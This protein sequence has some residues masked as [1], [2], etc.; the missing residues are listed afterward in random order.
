MAIR[1]RPDRKGIAALLIS[2]GMQEL[3]RRAAEEGKRYAVSISPDA[4]PYGAGYIASFRVEFGL[5]RKE[6]G[7]KRATSELWNDSD[8]AAAVEWRHGQRVL[9]RTADHI[10]SWDPQ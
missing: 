8:H 1:Y 7:S 3:C 9:G 10:E 4:P 5:V 6:A 2:P